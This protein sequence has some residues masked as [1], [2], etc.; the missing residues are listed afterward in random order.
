[1]KSVTVY[2]DPMIGFVVKFFVNKKVVSVAEFSSFS[3]AF[4]LAWNWKSA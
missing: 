3:L 2:S 1:M 4:G